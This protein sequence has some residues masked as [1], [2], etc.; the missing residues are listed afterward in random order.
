[1]IRPAASPSA[2]TGPRLPRPVI[3]LG[4]VSLFND[5][6]GD[7]INPLLPASV[8]SAPG[9]LAARD[10]RKKALARRRRKALALSIR[11]NHL[12][13]KLKPGK[14]FDSILRGSAK[15][16]SQVLSPQP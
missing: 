15:L 14:F 11:R 2:G 5:A 10:P 12:P 8:E 7:M 6:A 4:L 3:A 1:M 9:R 16:A 13:P